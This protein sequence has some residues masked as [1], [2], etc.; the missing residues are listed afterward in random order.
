MRHGIIKYY[1]RDPS[2][3]TPLA[4]SDP[5]YG[6]S[7]RSLTL[8][9]NAKQNFDQIS[10]FS[11]SDAKKF[12]QYESW[13]NNICGVLEK[14]LDNPPPNL[15]VLQT[16]RNFIEKFRLLRSYLS[17]FEAIKFFIQNYNDVYRLFT[18]PAADIL[19]EWFESDVLKATL[20]TDSVIGAMLSPESPGK[21]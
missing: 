2:G 20:A 4:E 3:Y 19:N 11:L 8:G 12:D 9:P 7:S 14:F 6:P 5:Q 18:A 1:T 13:L 15:S 21:L 10:R 17:D 16:K